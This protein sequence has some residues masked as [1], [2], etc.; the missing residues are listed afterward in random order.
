L[1]TGASTGIGRALADD[2]GVEIDVLV[3]NAGLAASGP[4]VDAAPERLRSLVGV[5][6][7]ALTELT[8]RLL[9]SMV[10]RGRGAIVNVASTAGY[11]PVPIQAAYAASKAYVLAFTRALWAEVGNTSVRVVAVSPGPTKTPMNPRGTR[12]PENVADTVVRALRR[13]GPDVIDGRVNVAI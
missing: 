4:V 6:V 1:V 8:V 11:Q 2:A 10:Q 9:P 5:N 3:N 13:R 7:T 12:R